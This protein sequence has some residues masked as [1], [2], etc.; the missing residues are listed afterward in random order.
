[1]FVDVTTTTVE[2]LAG[3][4]TIASCCQPIP[5]QRT[6]AMTTPPDDAKEKAQ[7]AFST[8]QDTAENALY[9]G[10][11]YM[12]ENKIAVILGAV[13]VGAVLGALLASKRRK[14]PDAVQT[15]RDWLEKTLEEF[16][17]QWPKAKK[18]ARSIQD[19][20]AAQAQ[21][22]SKKLHFWSR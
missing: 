22:F 2:A 20:L 17:K 12:R 1:M 14:E 6:I 10:G 4:D 8:A 5:N 21:G 19:D 18:Q 9:T 11:K 3:C 13:L 16:S 7:Q 15:V